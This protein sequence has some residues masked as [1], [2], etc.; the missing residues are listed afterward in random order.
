VKQLHARNSVYDQ[1]LKKN[2]QVGVA[3]EGHCVWFGCVV[4]LCGWGVLCFPQEEQADG[5]C[6]WGPLWVMFLNGGV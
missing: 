6:C 5:L 1:I 3:V 4:S 2:E